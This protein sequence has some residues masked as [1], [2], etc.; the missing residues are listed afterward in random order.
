[1]ARCLK[2]PLAAIFMMVGASAAFAVCVAPAPPVPGTAADY[3][4]AVDTFVRGRCFLKEWASDIGPHL[5]GSTVNGTTY[6]VHDQIKVYYSPAM[7]TWLQPNRPDGTTVP[8]QSTPIPDG[9]A[10]VAVVY[11]IAGLSSL[12]PTPTG[13]LVMIRQAGKRPSDP[14]SGWFFSQIVT[15]GARYSGTR[16]TSSMGNYSLGLCVACHASAVN[17]LTFASFANTKKLPTPPSYTPNFITQKVSPSLQSVLTPPPTS[18]LRQPLGDGPAQQFIDFFNSAVPEFQKKP[19]PAVSKLPAAKVLSIPPQST[20]DVYL[21]PAQTAF[22]TSNQCQGCHDTSALLSMQT[23]GL[24]RQWAPPATSYKYTGSAPSSGDGGDKFNISQ[25]GEWSVSIMALASRDPAFLSQVETERVLHKQV[26]P[27]AIDNFCYRCHGPMGQRQYHIDNGGDPTQVP[28]GTPLKPEPNFNHFMIYSTQGPCPYQGFPC[29]QPGAQPAFAKYGALARD[30]ISC[31]LC[32]HIGPQEGPPPTDPWSVFYGF[33]NPAVAGLEKPVGLPYPFAGSVL[34]NLKKFAAPQP[35]ELDGYSGAAHPAPFPTP[36]GTAAQI[37]GHSQN[38]SMTTTV[39]RDFIPKGE[40]C[41]GCHVVIAPEIPIGYPTVRNSYQIDPNNPNAPPKPAM[42]P[43]TNKPCPPVTALPNGKFDPTTDPCVQQSFEQTTYL[44]WAA[45]ASFGGNNPQSSCTYCHMPTAGGQMTAIANIDGPG[46]ATDSSG[47][48]SNGGFPKPPYRADDKVS[49]SANASYPR[50]RLMAINLF[51]HEMYQQFP[52]IL[53]LSGSTESAVPPGT[54]KNLQN[55]EETILTHAPTT[56]SLSVCK[57]GTANTPCSNLTADP[58]T[59]TYDV[60]VQN[61]S[62]HRFPTGAGFRRGFLEFRLLDSNS[63]TLWVSGAVNQFG[64]IVDNTGKV[65]S[66]E[67]PPGDVLYDPKFLQPHFGSKNNPAITRQDQVQIYEVRA[68]NEYSQL[69]SATTRLFGGAKDNRIPPAG[70]IPPYNCDGKI[71]PGTADPNSGRMVNG[72]DGFK[73][74][75][76][77]APEGISGSDPNVMIDPSGA[78]SDPDFCTPGGVLPGGQPAGIA[79][80]DHVL[81]KIPVSALNG[82][83]V[84]KVQVIMHY[85]SLPPYFLRDRYYDGQ[86]YSTPASEGGVAGLGAATERFLF[87]SSHLDTSINNTIPGQMNLPPWVSTSWTM[88]IGSACF[89]EAPGAQC[90]TAAPRP[91]DLPERQKL[92]S[93]FDKR[94]SQ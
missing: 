72:L 63:K 92:K 91:S 54:V 31:T 37:Y 69:T 41:G 9:A 59:L 93:I 77:T 40:L 70:W 10:M 56:I 43:N 74:S 19:L 52:D 20:D 26:E 29:N 3:Q 78:F 87:T 71:V 65:L 22:I 8:A 42:Y 13:Y 35:N 25:Y 5:S 58:N 17:N 81:Y 33:K 90:P 23:A 86:T 2:L 46:T 45:S 79:G 51:V 16:V 73:L 83:T 4:R 48:A 53:G 82:G 11:P 39:T 28:P 24:P 68:T 30:G 27:S 1:M 18:K 80:V 60:T 34:Y 88:D 89:A 66:T 38:F 94:G 84:A 49:V 50:H 64:A 14:A 21:R 67:F 7:L 61:F 62:G 12:E 57:P 6:S 75:R 76:I 55:A 36:S 15:D 47:A 85:Q 32:H 44:E